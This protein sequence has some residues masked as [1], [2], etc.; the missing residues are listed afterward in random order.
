MAIVSGNNADNILN[1]T[2]EDDHIVD[3]DGNDTINDNEGNDFVLWRCG[4]GDDFIDDGNGF[5]T[6]R[7][8]SVGCPSDN[9]VIEDFIVGSKTFGRVSAMASVYSPTCFGMLNGSLCWAKLAMT[10]RAP[11]LGMA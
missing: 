7:S 8:E 6:A 9:I 3:Q 4:D 1:G 5:D 11:K 10:R 2:A